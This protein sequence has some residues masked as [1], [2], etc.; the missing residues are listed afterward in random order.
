M[1]KRCERENGSHLVH[2]IKIRFMGEHQMISKR[3]KCIL[4]STQ[5]KHDVSQYLPALWCARNVT[6]KKLQELRIAFGTV[7]TPATW[8]Q[9]TKQRTS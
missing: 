6:K 4:R 1:N 9:K 3:S 5:P 7:L 8:K 2:A